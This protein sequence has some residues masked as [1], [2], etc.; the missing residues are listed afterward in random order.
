MPQS[1]SRSLLVGIVLIVCLGQ[2]K[3]SDPT[4]LDSLAPKTSRA[5]AL[6][7]PLHTVTLA[8]TSLEQVHLF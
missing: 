5:D 2:A 6:A 4:E 8:T 1:G 3:A 7:L